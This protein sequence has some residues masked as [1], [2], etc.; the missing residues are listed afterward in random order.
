LAG[1]SGAA[2]RIIQNRRRLSSVRDSML[3]DGRSA[4]SCGVALHRKCNDNGSEC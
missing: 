1:L 2:G 4:A 3:D